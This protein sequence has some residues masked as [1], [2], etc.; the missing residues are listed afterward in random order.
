ME[1]NNKWIPFIWGLIG[2]VLIYFIY[3]IFGASLITFF[4]TLFPLHL[5]IQAVKKVFFDNSEEDKR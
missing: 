3:K 5:V 1:F 4:M 2:L